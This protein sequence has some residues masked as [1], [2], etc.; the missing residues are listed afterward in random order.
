VPRVEHRTKLRPGSTGVTNPW[1]AST[2]AVAVVIAISPRWTVRS[3]AAAAGA[4]GVAGITS[5]GGW[6]TG[7]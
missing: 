7:G 1:A 2:V 5:S 4:A 3:T 6:A